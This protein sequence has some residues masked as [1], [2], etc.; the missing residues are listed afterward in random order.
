M[1]QT[2]SLDVYLRGE[3]VG[4][5]DYIGPADYRLTYDEGGQHRPDWTVVTP[6]S[7]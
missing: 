6:S 2:R 5:L 4:R 3:P 1:M 7:S